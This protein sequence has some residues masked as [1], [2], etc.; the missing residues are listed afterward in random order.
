MILAFAKSWLAS[1]KPFQS[2]QERR[3]AAVRDALVAVLCAHPD[4]RSKPDE[5]NAIIDKHLDAVLDAGLT[6][7]YVAPPLAAVLR[8]IADLIHPRKK[9]PA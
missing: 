4:R 5:L 7:A 6:W 9:D 8:S 2:F 3:R 1:Q